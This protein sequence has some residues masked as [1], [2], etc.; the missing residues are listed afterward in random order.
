M[1]LATYRPAGVAAQSPLKGLKQDLVVH[2]LCHEIVLDRLEE[3]AIADYLA[4]E[5]PQH[6]LPSGL[7][8]VIFRHS[9]GNA[10]FMAALVQDMVKRG[11]I[12]K[13]GGSWALTLPLEQVDPGVPETLQEMLSG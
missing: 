10:L 2:H 6:C 3:G 9:G 13:S 8:G 12:G 5:F 7:A 4:A 1:L 11:L